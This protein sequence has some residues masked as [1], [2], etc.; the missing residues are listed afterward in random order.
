MAANPSIMDYASCIS[1]VDE[2]Q[3][4]NIKLSLQSLRNDYA[5]LYEFGDEEL[6]KA[7]GPRSSYRFVFVSLLVLL[8]ELF[9]FRSVIFFLVMAHSRR[10]HYVFYFFIFAVVF[11]LYMWFVRIT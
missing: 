5:L 1:Q 7:S 4:F 2:T 3:F 10:I 8:V 9:V 11:S 6:G